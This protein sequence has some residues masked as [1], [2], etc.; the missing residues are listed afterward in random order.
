LDI[1]L[2]LPAGVESALRVEVFRPSGQLGWEYTT[3]VFTQQGRARVSFPLAWNDPAGPW[4]VVVT[5]AIAG[6]QA[7]VPFQLRAATR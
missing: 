3:N 4:R 7:I 6:K 1:R 5:D 2:Q